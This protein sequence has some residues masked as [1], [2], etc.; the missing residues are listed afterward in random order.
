MIGSY[1]VHLEARSTSSLLYE[2]TEGNINDAFTISPSTGV[3]VLNDKL[4]Y[5]TTRFYNL[6]VV[7]TNMAGSS[8]H[9]YVIIHVLDQNDNAPIFIQ[10]NYVGYIS[11][12][13]QFGAL[14]LT[15]DSS[16]LVIKA[17][18]AD[19]ELNSLLNYD[20]IEVLPRKYFHIDSNTGAIRTVHLLDH[21]TNDQFEFSVKVTDL[22]KPR[23]SSETT[24]SVK[25]IVT[26]VN[27]CTPVFT[28][29]EYNVTLLLPTYKDV[30]VTQVNA[31]DPDS[32]ELTTLRYDIIDGNKEKIFHIDQLTGIIQGK[33]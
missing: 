24:A 16:P 18:D 28:E 10:S 4:D 29:K 25:I 32:P 19:A 12:A 27:D 2:I 8:A 33:L 5:E 21:E 9:C 20:I 15:N 23:L 13:A 17:F 31:T 22:G 30:A 7:A 26:D 1:V 6:T 14:V 11:E 3:I